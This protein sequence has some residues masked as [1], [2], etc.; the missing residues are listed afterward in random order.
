MIKLM[1]PT[2]LKRKED[3]RVDASVLFT[4]ENNIINRSKG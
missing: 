3:R 4:R 1:D 2:K